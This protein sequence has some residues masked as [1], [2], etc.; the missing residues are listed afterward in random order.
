MPGHSAATLL[1]DGV[2]PTSLNACIS[3]AGRQMSRW[4][5]TIRRFHFRRS[6]LAEDHRGMGH[7]V[8][9][10]HADRRFVL[11]R[12]R[13]AIQLASRNNLAYAY[14][15]AGDLGRA[16][17]LYEATLA[18]CERVLGHEHPITKLVRSNFACLRD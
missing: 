15:A 12:Q 14:R 3:C 9:G 4:A 10:A 5:A 13:Q 11:R 6:C 16:I 8:Q 2:N 7:G 17:P 1:T 18:A